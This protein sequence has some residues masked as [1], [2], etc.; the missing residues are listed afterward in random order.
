MKIQKRPVHECHGIEG[1]INLTHIY[2]SGMSLLNIR[3][4]MRFLE[5]ELIPA[6]EGSLLRT[7]AKKVR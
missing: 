2:R 6:G 1:Q 4:E 7:E 3:L 5:I